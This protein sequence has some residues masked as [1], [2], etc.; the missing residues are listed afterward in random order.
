MGA[1]DETLAWLGEVADKLGLE[2]DERDS[3]VNSGMARQ[4]FK[5]TSSWTEPDDDKNGKSGGDFFSGKRRESRGVPS[6][7]RQSGGFTQYGS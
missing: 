2:D 1:V 3:F 5:Q 6:N 4:G 7:R